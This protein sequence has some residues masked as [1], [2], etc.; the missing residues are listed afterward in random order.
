MN[1]DI[2]P[3]VSCLKIRLRS[4]ARISAYLCDLCIVHISKY[5]IYV[6]IGPRAPVVGRGGRG[7]GRGQPGAVP[8]K[9]Y[10]DP[11]V[12]SS[13][14]EFAPSRLPGI[15]FGRPL[16]RNNMTRAVEF[17]YL[18]FT[19]EMINNICNHTNSYAYERI[20]EGSFQSYTEADGSWPEVTADEIKR[21]IAL[22]IYFGL[23][24]V[25][26]V[27][28]K[29][30]SRKTLYH[31]LWARAILPR[32]RFRALMAV[33][34]VVDPATE[35]PGDKLCKVESLIDYLSLDVLVYINPDK[36]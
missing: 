26:H 1:A 31:G 36:I 8:Y 9:T 6:P 30:W 14:P 24:K 21:L 33:L 5:Y 20:F 12:G 29:Y 2:F 16:L 10:S 27:D 35:A 4:Q 23:V 22:L 11:D 13:P 7:S 32:I 18:F 19:A 28:I 25:G 17:F 34:H 15:H 3:G